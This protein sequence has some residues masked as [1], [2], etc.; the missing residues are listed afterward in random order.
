MSMNKEKIKILIIKPA[1]VT[2]LIVLNYLVLAAF[3]ITVLA[4]IL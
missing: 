1:V 4:V 3:S 2:T